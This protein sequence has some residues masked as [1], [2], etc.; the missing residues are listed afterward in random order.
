MGI[1]RA[2]REFAFNDKRARWK[3][4]RTVM[5]LG[6]AYGV[7]NGALL[8]RP[9]EQ[10]VSEMAIGMAILT[11]AAFV[12]SFWVAKPEWYP[13]AH[14]TLRS[15]LFLVLVAGATIGINAAGTPSWERNF[16]DRRIAK[17]VSGRNV[18]L[19]GANAVFRSAQTLR[20]Q[21]TS[22]VRLAAAATLLKVASRSV[23]EG[24]EAWSSVEA[25]LGYQSAI[26]P[27]AVFE[28]AEQKREPWVLKSL[29][30]FWS[31]EP[32]LAIWRSPTGIR[33]RN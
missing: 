24:T 4:Y 29:P 7:L 28:N 16:V 13:Q 3:I 8:N 33:R 18:D 27:P 9:T 31:G 25:L 20:L 23:P 1:R 32:G 22:E 30:D 11:L 19:E 6:F 26:S 15:V 5:G 21:S 10:V 14:L 17:A 2:L 12:R